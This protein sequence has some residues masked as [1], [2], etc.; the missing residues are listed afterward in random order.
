MIVS[1]PVAGESAEGPAAVCF[2]L[3]WIM[4]EVSLIEE[5]LGT[6]ESTQVDQAQN[7]E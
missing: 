7:E 3:S 4:K 2:A 6:R 5:K 1:M